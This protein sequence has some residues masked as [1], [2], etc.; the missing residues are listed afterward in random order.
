LSVPEVIIKLP[1]GRLGEVDGCNA[2][3]VFWAL[4]PD[5]AALPM[6]FFPARQTHF[7]S[8]NHR[9]QTIIL[10]IHASH[11]KIH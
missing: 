8:L 1:S 4:R 3:A 9:H 11:K 2:I 6:D 10:F 7:G 5:I